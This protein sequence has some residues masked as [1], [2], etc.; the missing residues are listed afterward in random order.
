M[1]G[2][3]SGQNNSVQEQD[4][5]PEWLKALLSSQ[6]PKSSSTSQNVIGCMTEKASVQ[7][8]TSEFR[9][10]RTRRK[11]TQ[12]VQDNDKTTLRKHKQV[13]RTRYL[14]RGRVW[15]QRMQVWKL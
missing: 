3:P 1:S 12:E 8:D 5:K 14:D 6:H 10:A 7:D 4:G 11:A 2:S 9:E 13:L 15:R